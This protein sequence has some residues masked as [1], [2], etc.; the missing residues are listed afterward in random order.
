MKVVFISDT[1]GMHKTVKIPECDLLIHGGDITHTGEL[2]ILQ[3]FLEWIVE[4]NAKNIVFIAGNHDWGFV[5]RPEDCYALLRDYGFGI[6]LGQ[7]DGTVREAGLSQYEGVMYYLQDAGVTIDGVKIYGSP[8]QPWFCNWAFNLE[9]GEPLR[10]KWEMIPLGTDVVVT[11]GPPAGLG[12]FC[13]NM[14]VGCG[15]LVERLEVVNPRYHLCGHIHEGYGRR[16]WVGQRTHFLNGAI[17]LG[18][19]HRWQV[20][21]EGGNPP[22]EFHIDA[23]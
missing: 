21:P 10:K 14:H 15:D 20:P 19:H 18:K 22:H 12:D 23:E 17:A 13:D 16:S 3:D 7:P 9:R 1:H 11:H 6:Q 5:R 2:S 4:Q 8:W